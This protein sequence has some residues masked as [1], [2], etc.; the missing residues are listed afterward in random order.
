MKKTVHSDR[1]QRVAVI[2][3]FFFISFT[4]AIPLENWR[5]PFYFIAADYEAANGSPSRMFW[6]NTSSTSLFD[7]VSLD[8]DT[9]SVNRRWYLEPSLYSGIRSPRSPGVESSFYFHGDVY[10]EIRYRNFT[11]GQNLDVDSRYKYDPAYPAHRNRIFQGRIEEAWVDIG[12]Q[13]GGVSIGRKKRSWGPFPDRSLFLSTNP[14]S[15]DVIE[16]HLATSFFEFRHLVAPFAS[17]YTRLDSDNGSQKDRYFAAHSLNFILGKWATLGITETVL[18]TRN[19]SFPDLQYINPA[20]IFTVTNTNQ[21]G[22]GNI[23]VGFQWNIHPGFENVSLRGQLALDDIQV[24]DE[25]VTDQEPNHWALDAGAFWCEPVPGLQLRHCLALE[26]TFASEWIYTVSDHNGRNGERYIYIRKSLGLPFVDG[27]LLRVSASI[28]PRK[29]MALTL[30]GSYR[31]SG[32]NTELSRWNDSDSIYGLPVSIRRPTE[33]R[34]AAGCDFNYCFRN[35]AAFFFTGELGW[36]KNKG[37]VHSKKFTFDPAVSIEATLFFTG[38]R[39]V[40]PE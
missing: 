11:M 23:I 38:I 40:L 1:L 12:W 22:D 34:S 15:Y 19:G 39:K 6:D 2:T 28:I 32:G 20:S 16:L 27:S 18:F 17:K 3:L 29:T 4:S 8:S 24:D 9:D 36:I 7:G 31:R 21:E 25:K 30:Y 10:N 35:L 5:A 37:T 26:Y 13:Y 14:Y 33:R